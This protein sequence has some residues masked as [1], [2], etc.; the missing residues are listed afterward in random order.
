MNDFDGVEEPVRVAPVGKKRKPSKDGHEQEKVKKMR[1]S[2]GGKMPAVICRHKSS[3]SVCQAERLT[4]RDLEINFDSLYNNKTKVDQDQQ[5]LHL[6]TVKQVQR[7]RKKVDEVDRQRE[8]DV[9]NEYHLLSEHHPTKIPV[10]KAT[11]CGV[12]GE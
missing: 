10:C 7:R 1:H 2:G 11:F 8:R 9:T 6:I 4:E 3:R 5:L 12:L